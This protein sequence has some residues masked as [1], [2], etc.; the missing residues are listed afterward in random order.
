MSYKVYL[1][2]CWHVQA[3]AKGMEVALA[4][5]WVQIETHPTKGWKRPWCWE[6]LK[7]IG[8]GG[9][10]TPSHH[11]LNEYEFEQTPGDSEQRSLAC[12]SPWSCRVRHNLATEQQQIGTLSTNHPV[13]YWSENGSISFLYPLF[14]LPVP[15]HHDW[16]NKWDSVS[17]KKK[18]CLPSLAP[19]VICPTINPTL[20]RALPHVLVSKCCLN[21]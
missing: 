21:H 15:L 1:K 10:I 8:E 4:H 11:R 9:G 5:G 7:A 20:L 3:E 16:K 14:L 17:W 19:S 12:C 6:I 18:C 13:I 2:R